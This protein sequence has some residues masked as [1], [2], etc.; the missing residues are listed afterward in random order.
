MASNNYWMKLWF[1]ILRDPKMGMLPDR[2]WRRVIE[3]FLLAGQNGE[4]GLL[5]DV[6]TIAWLLNRSVQSITTDLEK[7]RDTGIVDQTPNGIWFVTNFKKRNEPVSNSE[8]AKD[9]RMR[10]YSEKFECKENVNRTPHSEKENVNRTLRSQEEQ[11]NRLTELT[12]TTT[13][14]PSDF[15]LFAEVY[16]LVTGSEPKVLNAEI[17]AVGEIIKAG[18]T[19]DDFRKALQGMQDKDYTIASMASALIWTL[20]DIDRR[21]Q[22]VRPNRVERKSTSAGLDEILDGAPIFAEDK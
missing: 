9:F 16:E 4:D 11:K 3:L 7:I 13:V 19:P 18:G 21:K 20:K 17:E 6:P 8:R 10:N 22:P 5:P 12:T 14:P 15:Q 2:L 1:D